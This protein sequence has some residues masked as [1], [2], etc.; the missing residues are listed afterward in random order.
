MAATYIAVGTPPEGSYRAFDDGVVVYLFYSPS[1][2][3]YIDFWRGNFVWTDFTVFYSKVET[4]DNAMRNENLD[5]HVRD[6]VGW[7]E[8][9]LVPAVMYFADDFNRRATYVF[10]DVDFTESTAAL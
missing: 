1:L 3:K 8:V 2:D 6:T 5:N 7:D 9:M 4:V 10:M